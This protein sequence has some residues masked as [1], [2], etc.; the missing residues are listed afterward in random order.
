LIS[1][2]RKSSRVHVMAAAGV[3]V[4]DQCASRFRHSNRSI[5]AD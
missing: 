4:V 2:E 3:A 1:F 5:S